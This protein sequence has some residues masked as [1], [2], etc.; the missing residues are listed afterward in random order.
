MSQLTRIAIQRG[1]DLYFRCPYHAKVMN[2]FETKSRETVLTKIPCSRNIYKFSKA[3]PGKQIP[4]VM[5]IP[6]FEEA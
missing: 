5:D 2:T 6:C 3:N 4:G 1:V